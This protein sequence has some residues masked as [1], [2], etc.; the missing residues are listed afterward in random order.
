MS[1]AASV[2]SLAVLE[3]FLTAAN[4][5]SLHLPKAPGVHS[6]P[7]ESSTMSLLHMPLVNRCK[8]PR[9]KL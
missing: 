1:M 7:K 4:C 9:L 2:D 8:L 6:S 3:Y 5:P